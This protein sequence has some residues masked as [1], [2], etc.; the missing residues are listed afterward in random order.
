MT[1]DPEPARREDTQPTT[2]NLLFVCTGNTC[3][4]P[5]AEAI[6]RQAIE[7]RAWTHVSVRSAGIS[8]LPGAPASDGAQRI[9]HEH[10]LDLSEHMSNPLT[11]D[12]IGWADLVLGMG[13]SHLVG[14]AELGGAE[15]VALVTDFLDDDALGTAIEDPFGGDD[16]AF[17]ETYQQLDHAISGLLSRL[18]PILAP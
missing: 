11:T 14:V 2:Y 7:R 8:T 13:P 1:F 4:S 3:R 5:L 15:K 16:D 10:G 6:A 18:E 12:L 17:R 9:A